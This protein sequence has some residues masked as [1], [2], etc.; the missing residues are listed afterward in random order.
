MGEK[1][2]TLSENQNFNFQDDILVS[3]IN[4]S[5]MLV[6]NNIYKSECWA[7][8][9]HVALLAFVKEKLVD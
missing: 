3:S 8:Q 1:K 4:K 9:T 5:G 6:V 2:T 7:I